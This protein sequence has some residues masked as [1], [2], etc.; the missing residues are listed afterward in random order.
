MQSSQSHIEQGELLDYETNLVACYEAEYLLSLQ[1]KAN[2]QC[3]DHCIVTSSSI[4]YNPPNA[5]KNKMEP[6]NG[7]SDKEGNNFNNLNSRKRQH[8]DVN[9]SSVSHTDN[10]IVSVA[11][12]Q[13]SDCGGMVSSNCW[14]SEDISSEYDSNLTITN[15]LTPHIKRMCFEAQQCQS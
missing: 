5:L 14:H 4:N 13:P 12:E 1:Y 11:T 7:K 8:H 6:R 10:W 9:S 2:C 3:S 15:Q